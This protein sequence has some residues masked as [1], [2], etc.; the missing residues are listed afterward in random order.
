[1]HILNNIILP[2]KPN[3]TSLSLQSRHNHWRFSGGW[4]PRTNKS[5]GNKTNKIR[6]LREIMMV[7]SCCNK[8]FK[9]RLLSCCNKG[10][11]SVS[12]DFQ[13]DWSSCKRPRLPPYTGDFSRLYLEC[14][15]PLQLDLSY[16]WLFTFWYFSFQCFD[17]ES[18]LK[19]NCEKGLWK[20]P[21][22]K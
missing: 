21:V 10:E 20:C 22:C 8:G 17:L 16:Y 18:Y 6:D 11:P 9:E 1:M 12:A 13:A 5:K 3:H 15:F 14:L 19:L 7:V 4:Q 2:S